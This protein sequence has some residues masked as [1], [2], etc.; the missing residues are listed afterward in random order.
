ML[1]ALRYTKAALLVF[2]FGLAL[3]FVLVVLGGHSRL[4]RAASALMALGLVL[5]PVALFAD[6]R[7]IALLR[8]LAGHLSRRSRSKPRGKARAA[9]RRKK[10]PTK[11]ISPRPTRA[12]RPS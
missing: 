4:E 11:R 10:A 5:I 1:R 6:G 7:G 3:G 8:W 12:K 9:P 2:G